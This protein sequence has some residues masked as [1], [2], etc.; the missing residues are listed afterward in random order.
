MEEDAIPEGMDGPICPDC[1]IP[2]VASAMPILA[3]D[4]GV[5]QTVIVCPICFPKWQQ[6]QQL[7]AKGIQPVASPLIVPGR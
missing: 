1:R 7:A 5:Y 3:P 2:L 6:K 4:A